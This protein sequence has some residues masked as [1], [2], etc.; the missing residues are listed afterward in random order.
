MDMGGEED[1][2]KWVKEERLKQ[3]EAELRFLKACLLEIKKF[4]PGIGVGQQYIDGILS[5]AN[6]GTFGGT[7]EPRE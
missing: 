2:S 3:A 5:D 7:L 1:M 6:S 4:L